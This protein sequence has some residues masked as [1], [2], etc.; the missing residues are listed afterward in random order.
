M[1]SVRWVRVIRKTL[2]PNSPHVTVELFDFR[3]AFFEYKNFSLPSTIGRRARAQGRY[4]FLVTLIRNASNPFARRLQKTRDQHPSRHAA[5]DWGV[6]KPLSGRPLKWLKLVKFEDVFDTSFEITVNHSGFHSR[7]ISAG[8]GTELCNK[9]TLANT[10][11]KEGLFDQLEG[12]FKVIE[13]M[14]T[15]WQG[16]KS[17]NKL[18]SFMQKHSKDLIQILNELPFPL[19]LKD[20]TT[21]GSKCSRE[22]ELI[23]QLNTFFGKIKTKRL[24]E[25]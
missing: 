11:K 20:K 17:D 1:S 2:F 25:F 5:N 7:K 19:K 6:F 10:L 13:N 18:K 16:D 23:D 4:T 12:K 15:S 3:D 8:N 24:S 9:L 22:A 14:K 21:R